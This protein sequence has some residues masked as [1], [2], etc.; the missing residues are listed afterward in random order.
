MEARTTLGQTIIE[1]QTGI[2]FVQFQ[3]EVVGDNGEVMASS[4]HRTAIQPGDDPVAVLTGVS[5]HVQTMGYPAIDQPTHAVV[6]SVTGMFQT[7]AVVKAFQALQMAA[8]P[9]AQVAP[10]A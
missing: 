10:L 3:L 5:D 7:P 2:V 8:E 6:A 9:P 4:N 1:H